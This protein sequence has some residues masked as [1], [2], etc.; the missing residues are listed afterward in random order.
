[1]KI[2]INVS[3]ADQRFDR[4]LRKYFKAQPE[5]SLTDIFSWIRKWAIK[6]NNRKRKQDYRVQEK[7]IIT[8]DDDIS[9]EKKS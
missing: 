2:I 9:T 3:N 6:V 8:R 1:M 4:F 7:D 5:I